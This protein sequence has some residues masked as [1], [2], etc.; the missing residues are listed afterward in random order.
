MR[1]SCEPVGQCYFGSSSDRG[2]GM[3]GHIVRLQSHRRLVL[4]FSGLV[5]LY[6]FVMSFL[7][8][9]SIGFNSYTVQELDAIEGLQELLRNLVAVGAIIGTVAAFVAVFHTPGGVALFVVGGVIA[10]VGLGLVGSGWA[11][12][13][14]PRVEYFLGPVPVVHWA[15][16]GLLARPSIGPMW[17]LPRRWGKRS[18]D[19]RPIERQEDYRVDSEVS[20]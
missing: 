15:T 9:T 13:G 7:V 8:A 19:A 16:A 10:S 3:D 18:A 2:W 12:V 5:G 6:G 14:G 17:S 20:Q 11:L 4:G 1:V